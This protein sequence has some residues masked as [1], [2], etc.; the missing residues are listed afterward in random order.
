MY[1]LFFIENLKNGFFATFFVRPHA[2]R[3]KVAAAK[4]ATAVSIFI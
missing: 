4:S 1:L 2:H 3:K